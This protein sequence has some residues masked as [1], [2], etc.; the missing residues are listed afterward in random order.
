MT[1]LKVQT[2]RPDTHPGHIVEV[3]W[4]YDMTAGRDTGREHRGVS[5]HYP[6]GTY[7][8]RDTH[9]A[10]V[11]HR[12]YL[13][14]H[15]EH[16]VKNQ[17]YKIIA[18]SLPAHMKKPMLDGDGAPVLDGAGQPALTLKDSHR[19]NFN[20]LGNGRYEFTVPGIDAVTHGEIVAKLSQ[21]GDSVVLLKSA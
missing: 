14:L 2:W 8:H 11:A 15:A 9:G 1:M 17:A 5:L 20:H 13:K 4:E 18:D 3:E 10:D 12:H 7:V 21:F 6:D 19:P 16:I